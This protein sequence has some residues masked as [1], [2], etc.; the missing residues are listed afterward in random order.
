MAI[1]KFLKRKTVSC[2]L[3]VISPGGI[4]LGR[5][6][7]TNRWDI[8]KGRREKNETSIEAALREAKE[9]TSIDFYPFK[10]YLIDLGEHYYLPHKSLHTFRL[11]IEETIELSKC[12]CSTFVRKGIKEHPE[13]DKYAWVQPEEVH[14]FVNP[15]LLKYL[16]ARDIVK[17]EHIPSYLW[18]KWKR[19]P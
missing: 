9:E 12:F 19:E 5:A 16:L 7:K 3:V 2:G 18:E 17:S 1:H 6:T 13:M 14:T 15:S 4:L 8:P 11:H 10:E